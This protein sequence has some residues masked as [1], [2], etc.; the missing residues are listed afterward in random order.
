MILFSVKSYYIANHLKKIISKSTTV[1][2]AALY[3][4]SAGNML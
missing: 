4:T 3:G 1:K 2:K